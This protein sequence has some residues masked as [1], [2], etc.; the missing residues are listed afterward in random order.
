MKTYHHTQR[1]ALLLVAMSVAAGAMLIGGIAKHPLLFG[2]PIFALCGWLFH[3]LTIEIAESELR[4]R[5]GPGWI[6]KRVSLAAITSARIVRT[7]VLE[8]WG[9]H[10][11]RFGWLYN[12]SGF[13]A[14]AITLKNGK[15]FC[16]GTDEPSVLMA[17]LNEHLECDP[18]SSL[19]MVSRV[20]IA[21]ES[22][23][24]REAR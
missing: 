11:S 20:V 22:A 23:P 19:R 18:S 5:F 17:K 10:L 24:W 13:D 2:M 3:S 7:N 6:H 4:W 8:G 21:P 1:G 16:L 12:V 15:G 14:V 9:I